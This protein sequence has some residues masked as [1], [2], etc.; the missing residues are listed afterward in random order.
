MPQATW[1]N[2]SNVTIQ[3]ATLECAQID[4]NRNIIRSSLFQTMLNGP[5]GPGQS[6]TL[7]SFPIGPVQQGAQ[8][9]DCEIVAV[10]PAAQ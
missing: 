9:A 7:Q 1:T 8:N 5:L 3:A 6:T 4:G 2:G 10:T